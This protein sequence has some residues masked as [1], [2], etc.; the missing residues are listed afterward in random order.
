MLNQLRSG[1]HIVKHLCNFAAQNRFCGFDIEVALIEDIDGV[2]ERHRF[3]RPGCH[4]AVISE[5]RQH[6]LCRYRVHRSVQPAELRRSCH[7]CGGLLPGD[8]AVRIKLAA[9]NT[10]DNAAAVG[11]ADVTGVPFGAGNVRKGFRVLGC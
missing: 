1:Q 11:C 5:L 9:A 3:L 7:H 10:V 2:A 6:I 8:G 4:A